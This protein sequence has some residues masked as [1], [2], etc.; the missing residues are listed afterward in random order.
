MTDHRP[1]SDDWVRRDKLGERW[2]MLA[3]RTPERLAADGRGPRFQIHRR[4][5]WYLASDV[6]AWLAAEGERQQREREA[7]L[8]AKGKTPQKA[9]RRAR[10]KPSAPT[11]ARGLRSKR[12]RF[13]A[14]QSN[15]C[16]QGRDPDA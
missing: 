12:A 6:E 5:A 3:G 15:G 14:A 4:W 10:P 9:P 1:T 16:S 13:L 11:P 2:P 7:A 8:K